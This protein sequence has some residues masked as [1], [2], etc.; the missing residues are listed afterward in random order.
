M[1]GMGLPHLLRLLTGGIT[2]LAPNVPLPTL[3]V[4]H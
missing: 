4:N 1:K 3:I 2:G